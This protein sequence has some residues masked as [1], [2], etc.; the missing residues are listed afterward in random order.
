M[1]VPCVPWAA[2]IVCIAMHTSRNIINHNAHAYDRWTAS[3]HNFRKGTLAHVFTNTHIRRIT[4]ER[5]SL[6]RYVE[7]HS[8]WMKLYDLSGCEIH[9]N[10]CAIAH[11]LPLFFLSCM[12]SRSATCRLFWL[13][14]VSSIDLQNFNCTLSPVHFLIIIE[15]TLLRHLSLSILKGTTCNV[16]QC[17]K[18]ERKHRKEIEKWILWIAKL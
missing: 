7:T 14:R 13:L 4:H 11:I 2:Y 12:P 5:D 17:R 6:C 3:R 15:E 18:S 16:R 1:M 9:I 8:F 10:L